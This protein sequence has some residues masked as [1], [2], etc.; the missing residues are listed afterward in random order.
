MKF[1][2]LHRLSKLVLTICLTVAIHFLFWMLLLHPRPNQQEKNKSASMIV[3]WLNKELPLEKPRD[4]KLEILKLPVIKIPKTHPY[5]FADV[6]QL[7]IQEQDVSSETTAQSQNLPVT[8]DDLAQKARGNLGVIYQELRK[9]FPTISK[10]TKEAN[11]ETKLA[12]GI[13]SAQ[14]K[15]SWNEAPK[16]QEISR[17]N[18]L[19]I[20]KV[21]TGVLTYCIFYST[22]H[23]SEGIDTMVN[24]VH[25]RTMNCPKWANKL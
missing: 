7:N 6:P 18:D 22:N 19:I 3:H 24:G 21:T 2:S 20:Y 23:N 5:V 8:Q 14:R 1:I 10:E 25:S 15:P 17:T 13:A 4:R 11:F 12:N 9:D 16:I